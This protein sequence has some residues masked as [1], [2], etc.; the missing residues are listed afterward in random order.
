MTYGIGQ[1]QHLRLETVQDRAMPISPKPSYSKKTIRLPDDLWAK[2]EAEG[3][4]NGRTLNAEVTARLLEA[5]ASP[6]LADLAQK[7]DET[8]QLVRQ[9]LD[10]IETLRIRK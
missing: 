10:E 8:R 9:V 5:Y 7:Q 2:A 3:A 1:K 4:K 6:T